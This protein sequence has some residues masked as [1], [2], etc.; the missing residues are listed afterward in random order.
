MEFSKIAALG[1]LCFWAG[2]GAPAYAE[3]D[4]ASQ[5]YRSSCVVCHGSGVGGAPKLGDHAAWAPLAADGV[6]AMMAIVMNGKG[7]MPPKGAAAS[8]SEEDLR[9]VVVYMLKKAKIEGL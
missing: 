7:A 4:V 1:T 8:A 9:R 6:E 2:V 5:L 3:D